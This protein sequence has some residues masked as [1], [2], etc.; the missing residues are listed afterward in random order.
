MRNLREFHIPASVKEIEKDAL[1]G[2]K[3]VT[4]YG[5]TDVA[6]AFA[7]AA[8]FEYVDLKPEDQQGTSSGREEK[9]VELPAV[10]R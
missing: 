9:A 7:E 10:K 6:E 8:G 5:S 3:D 4:V 1:E 2:C